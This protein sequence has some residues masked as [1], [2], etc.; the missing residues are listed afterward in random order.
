MNMKIPCC[1]WAVLAIMAMSGPQV[2]ANQGGLGGYPESG[3]TQATKPRAQDSTPA[4]PWEAKPWDTK[5]GDTKPWEAAQEELRP[6]GRKALEERRRAGRKA[7][8]ERLENRNG[9]IQPVGD[10]LGGT[11]AGSIGGSVG[12]SVGGGDEQVRGRQGK[13]R[14]HQMESQKY[15]PEG[16]R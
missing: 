2:A 10:S 9:D 1:R 13:W 6:G 12:G 5:P 15:Y 16:M 4:K 14:R 7:R 11:A 8:K 3:A